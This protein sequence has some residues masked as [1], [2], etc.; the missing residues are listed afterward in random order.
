MSIKSKLIAAAVA[1][2]VIVGILAY[3]NFVPF[4]ASI[5]TALA[6]IAGGAAGWA[7]KAWSDRNIGK[8]GKA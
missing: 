4:W 8:E 7:A 6:F 1:L 2:L 5:T 3:F